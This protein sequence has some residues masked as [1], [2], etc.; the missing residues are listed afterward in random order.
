MKIS[1]GVQ[2]ESKTHPHLASFHLRFQRETP[3]ASLFQQKLS[4]I[5]IELEI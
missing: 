5:E 3:H 1:C 2:R 4:E